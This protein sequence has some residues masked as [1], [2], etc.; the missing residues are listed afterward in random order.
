[1]G[2]RLSAPVAA[3]ASTAGAVGG[4]GDGQQMGTPGGDKTGGEQVEWG[5]WEPGW[6]RRGG[7]DA[8]GTVLRGEAEG[9]RDWRV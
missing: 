1:M 7:G 8:D 3:P 5:P 2:L 9:L 4:P 6:R